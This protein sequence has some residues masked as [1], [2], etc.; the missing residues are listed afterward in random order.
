MKRGFRKCTTYRTLLI[1]KPKATQP[2]PIRKN[3]SPHEYFQ[4]FMDLRF[5]KGSPHLV[6]HQAISAINFKTASTQKLSQKIPTPAKP[7]LRMRIWPRHIK[8]GLGRNSVAK[9]TDD[10]NVPASPS[11]VPKVCHLAP[12]PY[13]NPFLQQA[14]GFYLVRIHSWIDAQPI[15]NL[16]TSSIF[17]ELTT[18]FHVG[19]CNNLT[20][21]SSIVI[22]L[23][24]IY[25]ISIVFIFNFAFLK[26]IF[27]K[28]YRLSKYFHK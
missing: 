16:K 23:Y 24:M 5:P 1:T 9:L 13:I 2:F 3:N 15:P 7:I 26:V 8:N 25:L 18:G 28:A 10:R 22:S 4:P 11:F 17:D 20:Y 27:E 14:L 6:L 12:K 21:I 19:F